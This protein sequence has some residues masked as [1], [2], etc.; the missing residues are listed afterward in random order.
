MRRWIG[1]HNFNANRVG[2]DDGYLLRALRRCGV[3]LESAAQHLGLNPA[4]PVVDG[5]STL[6][7]FVAARH[8]NRSFGVL[9]E[10]VRNRAI[11]GPAH[12]SLQVVPLRM[13]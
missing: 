9:K 3:D 6:A 12:D 10:R 2:H 11:R 5:A 8:C 7:I 4:P 1:P 13:Y